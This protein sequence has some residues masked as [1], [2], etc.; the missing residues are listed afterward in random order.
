M[1]SAGTA[2]T[3]CANAKRRRAATSVEVRTVFGYLQ[4]AA[5][6]AAPG[7]HTRLL[8]QAGCQRIWIERID[9]PATSAPGLEEL[10][11]CVQPGDALVLWRRCHLGRTA[12]HRR[13]MMSRLRRDGIE[14]E[15]L[16]RCSS[17]CR[18][19]TD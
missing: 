8:E 11:V 15:V 18:C 5:G 2:I 1:T 17:S 16:E 6:E 3:L 9:G 12:E 7:G 13:L 14:I 10:L 19:S 4:T